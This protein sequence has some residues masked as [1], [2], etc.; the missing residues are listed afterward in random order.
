MYYASLPL[1]AGV[2]PVTWLGGESTF[3]ENFNGFFC[4]FVFNGIKL[5]RNT[6]GGGV[7][8]SLPLK[9]PLL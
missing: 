6:A 4:N 9:P 7:A 3:S 1:N 8:L 2:A 5:F